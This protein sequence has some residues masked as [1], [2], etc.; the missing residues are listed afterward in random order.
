MTTIERSA[1]VA[2]SAE[3]MFDLVN[4]TERYPE[5]FGWCKGADVEE[6]TA[7]RSVARLDVGLGAFKTWFKTDNTLQRPERIH[8]H[9]LA[10]PFKSLEGEWSFKALAP[11]ACK[12]QLTLR[13]EPGSLLLAPVLAMGLQALADRMVDDFIRAADQDA[14]DE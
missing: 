11:H 4:E 2:H 9:L 8:M 1:L 3:Q 14:P 13:F 5:R 12:V 7:T 6:H 10:G